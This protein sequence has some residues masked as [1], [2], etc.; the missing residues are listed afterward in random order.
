MCCRLVMTW[1][2]RHARTKFVCINPC[3]HFVFNAV[4]DHSSGNMIGCP[5]YES[6]FS[7]PRKAASTGGTVSGVLGV[8]GSL[9]EMVAAFAPR[10]RLAWRSFSQ[11]A[12]PL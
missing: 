6:F 2:F 12:P 10:T 1:L 3:G 7:A 11:A 5:I 9:V 4:P 8:L